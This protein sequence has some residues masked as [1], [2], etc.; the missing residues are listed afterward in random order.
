MPLLLLPLLLAHIKDGGG[1]GEEH[2][3]NFHRGWI[4]GW[5][6]RLSPEVNASSR[7]PPLISFSSGKYIG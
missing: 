4:G 7:R 5:R 2:P 3:A 1:A 6:E